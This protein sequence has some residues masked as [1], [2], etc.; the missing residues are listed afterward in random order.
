M[1]KYDV[2]GVDISWFAITELDNVR[3]RRKLQMD[4]AAADICHL[5]FKDN[6]FDAVVAFGVLQHLLEEERGAVLSE[7]QRVLVSGGTIVIEVLGREDMRLGGRELERTTFLRSTGSVYHYFS[8]DEIKHIFS[9]MEIIDIKENRIIKNM[10]G[11][12][13]IRHMISVA[14]RLRDKNI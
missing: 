1:R 14:A 6:S 8:T 11:K 2:T 9:G 10:A 12:D 7:F 3:L 4:L 5:P 13:H